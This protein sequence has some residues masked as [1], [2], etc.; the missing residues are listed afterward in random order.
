MKTASETEEIA[1]L[2]ARIEAEVL[3][4]VCAVLGGLALFTMTAWLVFKGGENVGMHLQL[5]AQYFPGY[6]VTWQGSFVGLFYGVLVGGAAGWLIGMIY[7]AVV[8]IRHR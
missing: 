1:A 5:L 6:S 2:V 7:N 4:L 3:A 8:W